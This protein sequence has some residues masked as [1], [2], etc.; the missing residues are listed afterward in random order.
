MGE[1]LDVIN[2]HD[3]YDYHPGLTPAIAAHLLE[4]C[5]VT[6]HRKRHQK[7]KKVV[8]WGDQAVHLILDWAVEVNERTERAWK[9]QNYATE[10]AAVCLAIL[11]TLYFTGN[12]VM[13]RS[14][15]GTGFDYWIGSSDED[16]FQNKA[17][18]E[19]SGIFGGNKTDMLRVFYEKCNQTDKS[20]FTL[21]RAYV[22]VTEFSNLMSI[23]AKKDDNKRVT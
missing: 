14:V 1:P 12:R 18:L 16:N 11:F 8:I 2:L 3:I 22:S 6:L 7:G 23:Y 4:G 10:H 9:D 15:R 5:S 21:L 13:E 20:D 19:I 17:R